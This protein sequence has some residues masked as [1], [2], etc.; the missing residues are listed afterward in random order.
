MK[1]SWLAALLLPFALLVFVLSAA[2]ASV[3][4]SDM[5]EQDQTNKIVKKVKPA[6]HATLAP[7]EADTLTKAIEKDRSDTQS[8][9]QSAPTSYLAAIARRD[10]GQ[11][12]VLNVGREATNDVRLTDST[13]M[14]RHLRVQVLGDSFR[15]EGLDA[16]ARFIAHGD[17]L[18]TA[19][20]GPGT[21]QVGRYT[22][23]LSHQHY[24]AIIVFDPQSPRL[25]E[26]KGL[27][28]FPIDFRY[29]FVLPLTP[30]PDP[31][32][33]E[34]LSTHSQ[35]R[36]AMRAGWFVFDVDGK[37]CV[38]EANRLLEP[39]VGEHDVSVFFRDETTGKES[40]DVGRYVDP[41]RLADGRYVLDF[42]AAYNPACATSPH[43]NCPIPPK[44]NK[45]KVAIK[46]GE[47]NS[48]YV[49]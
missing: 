31:D 48:H 10:F 32:T 14:A 43:Y 13:I 23:R 11:K 5:G 45:L 1:R 29:R 16:G 8:W 35:P 25:K 21:L 19:T 7:G 9:L 12:T 36:Q 34:I 24:P 40:Y 47:K 3:S 30:N 26:Y 28:Y 38:L 44:F 37:K 18:R 20:L 39:G 15:V 41:E 17:T 22:L 2:H 49:H 6:G 4:I 33:V 42:N 27:S 46:A